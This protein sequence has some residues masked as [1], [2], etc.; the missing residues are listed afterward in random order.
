MTLGFITIDGTTYTVPV[1]ECNRTV[2]TLDFYAIR[3]ADGVL[4]RQ[5]IGVYYNYEVKFARPVTSAV[6]TN[7]ALLWAALAQAVTSH[8]ITMPDGYSSTYYVGDGMKDNVHRVR[9][10]TVWWQSLTSS[11][12]QIAPAATP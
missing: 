1:V 2:N 7:Y 3:T 9:S 5:L 6:L 8:T 11:F 4:H 10:A 12:V